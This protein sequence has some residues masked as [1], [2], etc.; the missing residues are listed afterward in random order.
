MRLTL[1]TTPK[2][3]TGRFHTIQ[4]HA[5][6]SWQR[7]LPDADIL[8][9]GDEPGAATA[10]AEL[11][12]RHLPHVERGIGDMPTV[13]ALFALAET[14]S[15]ADYFGYI[16][17]DILLAPDATM[18]LHHASVLPQFL[19]VGQRWNAHQSPDWRQIKQLRHYA[20]RHCW[21]QTLRGSDYFFYPRGQWHNLP[22]LVI[23]RPYWDSWLIA[24]ALDTSI[25]VVDATP[26]LTAIHQRH[27]AHYQFGDADSTA[28]LALTGGRWATLLEANHWLEPAGLSPRTT[29]DTPTYPHLFTHYQHQLHRLPYSQPLRRHMQSALYR[30]RAE[31]HKEKG[32]LTA[33]F[34]WQLR[35]FALIPTIYSRKLWSK[36][37]P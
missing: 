4:Y 27:P 7:A 5:L 8:L 10:A 11:G 33:A 6:R 12:L 15:N 19:L 32:H 3:F 31:W 35:A 29:P 22:P 34:L 25:P 20:Y 16:N 9:I 28:N 23:G 36:L 14:T 1:F 37:T 26:T 13:P 2:P 17:A 21:L 30:H 18:A 24:H